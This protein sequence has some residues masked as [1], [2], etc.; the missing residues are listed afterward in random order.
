M[1]VCDLPPG[2]TS[3]FLKAPSLPWF[4][5]YLSVHLS[6]IH[7]SALSSRCVPKGQARKVFSGDGT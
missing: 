2:S 6:H 5:S 7:G 1:L 3:A 4:V